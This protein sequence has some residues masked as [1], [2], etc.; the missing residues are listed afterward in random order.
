MPT[1]TVR[2]RPVKG[3]VI[4]FRVMGRYGVMKDEM[5]PVSAWRQ[6]PWS[7]LVALHPVVVGDV[8]WVPEVN[9]Q[10]GMCERDMT[11]TFR[12]LRVGRV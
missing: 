2:T 4:I 7:Y 1:V 5:A 9:E 3:R 6:Y 8:L 10:R 11:L 12:Y